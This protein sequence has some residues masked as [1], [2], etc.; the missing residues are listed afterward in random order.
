MP[1][2]DGSGPR[3]GSRGPRN[4]QGGGRRRV[5]TKGIGRKKGGRRGNCK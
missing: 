2:R 1:N 4:G 5:G 3:K